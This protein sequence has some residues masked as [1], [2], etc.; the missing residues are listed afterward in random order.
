MSPVN[1]FRR[2]AVRFCSSSPAPQGLAVTVAICKSAAKCSLFIPA[3][4]FSASLYTEIKKKA[5]FIGDNQVIGA[6]S[7]LKVE[8]FGRRKGAVCRGVL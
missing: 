3:A 6:F 8:R 7:A 1:L 5:S 2:A 4:I